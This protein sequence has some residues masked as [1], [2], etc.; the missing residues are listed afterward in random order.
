MMTVAVIVCSMLMAGT[1]G[2]LALTGFITALALAP[3]VLSFREVNRTMLAVTLIGIALIAADAM[4]PPFQAVFP[5]FQ[6]WLYIMTS[7]GMVGLFLLVVRDFQQYPLTT[8]LQVAFLFVALGG[9][10]LH[11]GLGGMGMREDLEARGA[12]A[13]ARGDR[14]RRS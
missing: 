12:A 10:G 1:A 14:G 5:L 11:V 6:T 7:A 13:G 3:G 2:S 9:V 8:K 4:G